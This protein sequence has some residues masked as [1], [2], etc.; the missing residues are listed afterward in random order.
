MTEP[1][2]KTLSEKLKDNAVQTEKERHSELIRSALRAVHAISTVPGIQD[3]VQF[4]EL[5]TK[6]IR[7]NN[8]LNNVYNQI[9]GVE[10]QK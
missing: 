6:T 8:T 10:E 2:R 9:S 7:T 4:T 5:I 1:L 3:N